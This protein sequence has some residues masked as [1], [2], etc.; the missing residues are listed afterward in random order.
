[1]FVH[2]PTLD[3]ELVDA[4]RPAV[5][6]SLLTERFLVRVPFDQPFTPTRVLVR[7]KR[8]AGE[9]L[10]PRAEPSLRPDVW[11]PLNLVEE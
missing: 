4:E 1:V 7:D 11:P 8:A 6:V 10:A 2:R 9:V 3:F 5:V